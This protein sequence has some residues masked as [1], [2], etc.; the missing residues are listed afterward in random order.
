M[1][2]MNW[3]R[4]LE[5]EGDELL[6]W[7]HGCEETA[8]RAIDGIWAF[9]REKIPAELRNLL[10]WSIKKL[11]YGCRVATRV[12][13]IAGLGLAWLAIVGGPLAIYPNCVTGTWAV[14]ASVGSWWGLQQQRIIITEVKGVRRG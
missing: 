11:V 6:T 12:A 3:N 9:F 1:S 2:R 14:L 10:A 7:L 4:W 8:K 5:H 13:R